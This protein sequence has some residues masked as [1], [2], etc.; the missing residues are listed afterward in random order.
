MSGFNRELKIAITSLLSL[1]VI[2]QPS[3]SFAKSTVVYPQKNSQIS[4]V[5]KKKVNNKKILPVKT[6][7]SKN[8]SIKLASK[9]LVKVTKTIK[10]EGNKTTEKETKIVFVKDKSTSKIVAKTIEEKIEVKKIVEAKIVK[11]KKIFKIE[12]SYKLPPDEFVQIV[13]A[14]LTPILSLS[15]DK[16]VTALFG[17]PSLPSIEEVSQKELRLAGL[18]LNPA[19]NSLSRTDYYN[20][21]KIKLLSSDKELKVKGLPKNVR[22]MYPDWSP[23]GKKLAF[24]NLTDTSNELWIVDIKNVTAKKVTSVRLNAVTGKP[25]QWVSDSEHIICNVIPGD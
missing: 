2:S 25:Y 10:K 3:Y 19:N 1:L 12:S 17:R 22:V 13:N 16:V 21:I 24:I 23:N 9:D 18:R 5:T 14:P 6:S 11:P 7:N 20:D 4:T 15:P 8:S